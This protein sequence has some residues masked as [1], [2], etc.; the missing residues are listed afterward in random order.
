MSSP[1]S[2]GPLPMGTAAFEDAGRILTRDSIMEKLY[3]RAAGP[4]DSSI[5]MHVSHLRRKLGPCGMRIKTV[6]G[7]GY[8]FVKTTVQDGL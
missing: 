7:S 6:R 8:Q 2:R 3:D 5:D 4:F 1:A